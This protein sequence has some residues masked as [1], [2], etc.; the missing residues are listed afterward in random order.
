MDP[1]LAHYPARAELPAR[2]DRIE[3][4]LA[5]TQARLAGMADPPPLP[6]ADYYTSRTYRAA[7]ACAACHTKGTATEGIP[8]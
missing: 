6:D 7:Y 4:L 5:A 3:L 1:A 8:K 2:A